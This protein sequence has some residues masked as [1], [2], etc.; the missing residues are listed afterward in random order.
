MTVCV[1]VQVNEC[2]VFAA[3]SAVTLFYGVDPQGLDIINV[4]PHGYKVFNLHRDLPISAMTCGLGNIGEASVSSL[5]KDLRIALMGADEGYRI[6]PNAYSIEEVA[7]KA[8][9]Y[10]FE[11]RYEA[12]LQKLNSDL[13]FMSAATRQGRT[14]PRDGSS[15]LN[16]PEPHPLPSALALPASPD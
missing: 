1:A 3:D 15:K 12:L 2:L 14:T 6:G 8:R 5:A 9:R 10:L 7:I 13:T 16:G 4:L 11:E